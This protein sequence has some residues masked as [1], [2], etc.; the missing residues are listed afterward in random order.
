[1]KKNTLLAMVFLFLTAFLSETVL[2]AETSGRVQCGIAASDLNP[3]AI[4]QE[5]VDTDKMFCLM[6][7]AGVRWV[8]IPV[9]WS[10]VQ[11]S[12]GDGYHFE[13]FDS[14]S[15]AG[16]DDIMRKA[17]EYGIN[18]LA[19]LMGGYEPF[20]VPKCPGDWTAG[21]YE[22]WGKFIGSVAERYR[23]GSG[24]W[25]GG[26]YGVT[27]WQIWNE[28][29]YKMYWGRPYASGMEAEMVDKSDAESY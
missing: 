22:K 18:V 5:Q 10:Q 19:I 12:S 13:Q 3:W 15:S 29:S 6:K 7:E 8:R 17:G 4:R 26:S 20:F 25:N 9:Y 23:P 1:M 11:F 16:Y 24:F 14:S 28:P 27:H 2:P 21:D